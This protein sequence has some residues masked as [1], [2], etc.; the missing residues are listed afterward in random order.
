MPN[1]RRRAHQPRQFGTSRN[2]RRPSQS[3][4]DAWAKEVE[5]RIAARMAEIAFMFQPGA[6]ITVLI[7]HPSDD[8]ADVCVTDD[9]FPDLIAM[10]Q[11]CQARD[12]GGVQ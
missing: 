1:E 3:V 7:R 9:E 10:L 11:R 12:A 4:I 5:G 2:L 6:K 8:D